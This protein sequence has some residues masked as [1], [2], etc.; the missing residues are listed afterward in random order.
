[1]EE[2]ITIEHS[3][4][5]T[6]NVLQFKTGKPKDYGFAPGQATEYFYLCGPPEFMEAVEMALKE[7]GMPAEK[8]VKEDLE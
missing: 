3:G 4:F 2:D 8:L 6:H 7:L 5:I 1:M